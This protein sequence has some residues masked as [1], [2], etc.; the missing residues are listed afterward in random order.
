M[1]SSEKLPIVAVTGFL[2][3]GKTTF[4]NELIPRLRAANRLVAVLINEMG[5]PGIDAEL[6]GENDY[7]TS[8]VGGSVFCACVKGQLIPAMRQIALEVQP[9]VLV[10]EA[11]GVAD[12]GEAGGVASDQ[13]T[14]ALY[15]LACTICLASARTLHKVVQTLMAVRRQLS[16]AD[17]VV[18]TGSDVASPIELEST[19]VAI[20]RYAKGKPVWVAPYARLPEEAWRSILA[21]VGSVS[22]G[23]HRMP[24]PISSAAPLERARDMHQ[25]REL[26]VSTLASSSALD[27]LLRLLPPGTQ[28]AKGFVSVAGRT[29]VFQFADGI[30]TL[31]K[32]S[33]ASAAVGRIMVVGRY[34]VRLSLSSD[35]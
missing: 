16:L 32:T 6:V 4:L 22:D 27:D 33:Q 21:A 10:V 9:D 1:S 20:Q 18:V 28:R 13:Q 12:P 7:I 24:I 5:A 8:I 2:G 30:A 26:R 17:M 31:E 23:K 11:T 34:P 29:K 19:Q 15:Q 25:T 3:S 35:T 14:A